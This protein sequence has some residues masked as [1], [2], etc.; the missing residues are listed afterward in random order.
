MITAKEANEITFS[1][2]RIRRQKIHAMLEK[3][4]QLI[5]AAANEGKSSISVHVGSVPSHSARNYENTDLLL[6]GAVDELQVHGFATSFHPSGEGYVPRGLQDDNGD[7][8]VYIN[9]MLVIE[10]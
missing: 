3:Y 10:W 5:T 6:A 4:E 8:P 9:M 1:A 2:E 7:G